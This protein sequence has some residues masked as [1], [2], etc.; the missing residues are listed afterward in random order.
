MSL[1]PTDAGRDPA[2]RRNHRVF[3][4]FAVAGPYD[5][6]KLWPSSP[7]PK[8]RPNRPP[9]FGQCTV[10]SV[11]W[12]GP[13]PAW[14]SSRCS[15]STSTT[16]FRV[17]A[18]SIPIKSRSL[19]RTCLP[20]YAWNVWQD[21]KKGLDRRTDEPYAA[22]VVR[23]HIWEAVAGGVAA[24]RRRSDRRRHD[25]RQ[26]ARRPRHPSIGARISGRTTLGRQLHC[27]PRFLCG[28]TGVQ[29]RRCPPD[30]SSPPPVDT[31]STSAVFSI[32]PRVLCER[33]VSPAFFRPSRTSNPLPIGHRWS[34]RPRARYNDSRPLA[35]RARYAS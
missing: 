28:H 7:P 18:A 19:P 17:S 35:L 32:T 9:P 30:K 23:F 27:R 33:P 1:W 24:D 5:A 3:L 2:S 11:S 4:W 21:M 34:L 15:C 31:F 8:A 22:A 14:Q 26:T 10:G 16:P 6:A 20:L 25:P 13:S 29:L 12:V